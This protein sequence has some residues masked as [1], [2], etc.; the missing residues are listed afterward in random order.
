MTRQTPAHTSNDYQVHKLK[1]RPL[2]QWW[3]VADVIA[4]RRKNFEQD[5]FQNQAIRSHLVFFGTLPFAIALILHT[6]G[7]FFTLVDN[8][9]STKEK[10]L[11]LNQNALRS[12]R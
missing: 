6:V 9:E 4:F 2:R 11:E 5:K 3:Q 7:W 12:V 1:G 8:N 10:L